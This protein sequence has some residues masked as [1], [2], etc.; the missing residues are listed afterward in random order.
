MMGDDPW[1]HGIGKNARILNK[2]LDYSNSQGLIRRKP[3]LEE[4][5]ID[6]DDQ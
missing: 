2:F 6:L 1:A 4:L 3:A 5:F